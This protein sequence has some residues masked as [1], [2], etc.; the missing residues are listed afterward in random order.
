MEMASTS[1]T[2]LLGF[3]LLPCSVAKLPKQEAIG[4]VVSSMRVEQVH[5]IFEVLAPILRTNFSAKNLIR[6]R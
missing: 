1:L 4:A 3:I 6:T 2:S 5:R